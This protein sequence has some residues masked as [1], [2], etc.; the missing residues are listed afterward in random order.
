MDI[1]PYLTGSAMFRDIGLRSSIDMEEDNFEVEQLMALESLPSFMLDENVIQSQSS[2]K[3]DELV[4]PLLSADALRSSTEISP[5]A[6]SPL[7]LCPEI[8]QSIA[9]KEEPSAAPTADPIIPLVDNCLS[10]LPATPSEQ[11]T[12]SKKIRIKIQ[13]YH[14]DKTGPAPKPWKCDAPDCNKNF[15]DSSN[16][17]KHLRTHT[18]EKP[19]VC[20]IDGC[21]KSFSHKSSLKE[22]SNTHSGAKPFACS[23]EGCGKSFAQQANLRRHERTH[24]GEKPYQCSDC[25]KEFNQSSNFKQHQKIHKKRGM[26]NTS[27]TPDSI[28]QMPSAADSEDLRKLLFSLQQN[29]TGSFNFQ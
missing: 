6:P 21:G 20:E 9:V 18:G 7:F 26:K 19:Y 2:P 3:L 5:P 14:V 25:G 24:T 1:P 29:E 23:F 28:I 15:S 27:K 22:H 8:S 4:A 11:P 16:L 13:I 10:P 12:E 17:L